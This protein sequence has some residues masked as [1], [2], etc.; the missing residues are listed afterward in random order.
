M[1]VI[2]IIYRIPYVT[3]QSFYNVA[4]SRS[5]VLSVYSLDQT[6]ITHLGELLSSTLSLVN[7]FYPYE[8]FQGLGADMICTFL[9]MCKL[10]Q[11]GTSTFIF[12]NTEETPSPTTGIYMYRS[13][14]LS[15][16]NSSI[17]YAHQCSIFVYCP[18]CPIIVHFFWT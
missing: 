12:A 7:L 9:F 6:Q 15:Y 1:L 2:H 14:C 3:T 13:P 5:Y 16:I 8:V 18:W 4:T 10:P 17:Y 11:I